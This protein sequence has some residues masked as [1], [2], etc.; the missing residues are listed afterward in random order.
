MSCGLD[1]RQKL[2]CVMTVTR[3]LQAVLITDPFLSIGVGKVGDGPRVPFLPQ[4]EQSTWKE[5]ILTH[6]DKVGKESTGCLDHSDLTVRH[7]N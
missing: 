6:D 7:S 1:W 3:A 5:P 2:S 4:P